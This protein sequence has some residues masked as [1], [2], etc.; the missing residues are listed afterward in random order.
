[1]IQ[2]YEKLEIALREFTDNP[3]RVKNFA[4]VSAIKNI[5][6]VS[7]RTKSKSPVKKNF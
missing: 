7:L 6:D 4:E 5:Y 2:K 1:M 3:D